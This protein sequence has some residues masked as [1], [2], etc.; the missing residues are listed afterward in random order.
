MQKQKNDL[1]FNLK[2]KHFKSKY[3]L[4]R[5]NK[6]KRRLYKRYFKL[7]PLILNQ[8]LVKTFNQLSIVHT[9]K[10]EPVINKTDNTVLQPSLNIENQLIDQILTI[11]IRANN[12]FCTLKDCNSLKIIKM[13]SAGKYKIN[14]S[15]KSLN[16][17]SKVIIFKFVNSIQSLL[18]KNLILRLSV[19]IKFKKKILK[20]I[21]DLINFKCRICIF[22]IKNDKCFNGCRE[23][24]KNRKK[25]KRFK[26][27]KN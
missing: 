4:N 20:I 12:V 25:K 3:S 15:K 7:L 23:R 13:C 24:K 19:P 27:F 2:E 8:T 26:I 14:V 6:L 9:A 10:E 22:E 18:K 21:T 17:N 1:K 5:K 16:F 11:K